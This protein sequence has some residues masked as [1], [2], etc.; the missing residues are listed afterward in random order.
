MLDVEIDL[1]HLVQ[2]SRRMRFIHTLWVILGPFAASEDW[3]KKANIRV[4]IKS[5]ETAN[6]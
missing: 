1:N 2:L 6:R 3:A 5:I 4:K